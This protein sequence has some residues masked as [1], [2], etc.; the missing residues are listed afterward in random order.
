[1]DYFLKDYYRHEESEVL[2]GHH[3][4]IFHNLMTSKVTIKSS[5]VNLSGNLEKSQ[6]VFKGY[7]SLLKRKR[8]TSGLR[9]VPYKIEATLNVF[10]Q[11][12]INYRGIYSE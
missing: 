6:H 11:E 5:I 10:F 7:V 9:R 2:V 4:K 1:M 3:Y 8:G 12:N